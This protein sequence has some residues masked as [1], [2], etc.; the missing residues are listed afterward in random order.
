MV[1]PCQKSEKI[2]CDFLMDLLLEKSNVLVIFS[3]KNTTLNPFLVIFNR[4]LN[5]KK[6]IKKEE[7]EKNVL[8]FSTF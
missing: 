8:L 4:F 7:E 2:T 3:N 1:L 6:M 5:D